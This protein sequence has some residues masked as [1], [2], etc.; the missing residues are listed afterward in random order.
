[1]TM[2]REYFF[3][4]VKSA[5]RHC[6]FVG[7]VVVQYDDSEHEAIAV[8][9]IGAPS[10]EDLKCE[11]RFAPLSAPANAAMRKEAAQP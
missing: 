4:M 7:E 11:I 8:G 2:Q 6:G 3:Q 1:M 10:P 5:L 9:W